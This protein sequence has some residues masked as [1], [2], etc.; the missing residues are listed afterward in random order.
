MVQCVCLH[1]RLQV[2]I[3]FIL[4]GLQLGTLYSRELLNCVIGRHL[5]LSRIQGVPPASLA[6]FTLNAGGVDYYDGPYSQALCMSIST[7]DLSLP[8]RRIQLAPRYHRQ[9]WLRYCGLPGR[10]WTELFALTCPPLVETTDC[11]T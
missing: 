8:R 6:E 9:C 5:I 2:T 7:V 11:S 4:V 3:G 10:P 1:R